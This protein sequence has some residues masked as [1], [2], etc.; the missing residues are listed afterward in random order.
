MSARVQQSDLV[1]PA[2]ALTGCCRWVKH[3]KEPLVLL[4][5]LQVFQAGTVPQ[6]SSKECLEE[7]EM[8]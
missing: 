3:N 5:E 7:M 2:L 8:Y 6:K 4:C 1:L